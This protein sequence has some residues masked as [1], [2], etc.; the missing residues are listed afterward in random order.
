MIAYSCDKEGEGKILKTHLKGNQIRIL[1][2]SRAKC[3]FMRKQ[4]EN[5]RDRERAREND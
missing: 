5:G 2:K 4:N 3:V 1:A